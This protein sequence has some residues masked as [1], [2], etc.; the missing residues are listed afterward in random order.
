M[1]MQTMRP[2][3]NTALTTKTINYISSNNYFKKT[4]FYFIIEHINIFDNIDNN[5]PNLKQI[6]QVVF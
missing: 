4:L 5:R 3:T 1:Q 6:V 2:V